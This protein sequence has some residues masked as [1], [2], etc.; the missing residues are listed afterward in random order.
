MHTENLFIDY[1]SHWQ[2]IKTVRKSFP[3]LY[4]VPSFTFTI[5]YCLLFI[6]YCLL[7]IIVVCDVKKPTN[8][9]VTYMMRFR[10]KM[11]L[12]ACDKN[13]LKLKFSGG[14]ILHMTYLCDV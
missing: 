9:T 5:V 13:D 3:Q 8:I 4:S 14:N 10:C 6:D 2:A 12:C 7:F 11:K 1:C